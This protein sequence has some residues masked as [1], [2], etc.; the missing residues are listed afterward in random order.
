M[1]TYIY[2]SCNMYTIGWIAIS[3]NLVN[4]HLKRNIIKYQNII[5]ITI[6]AWKNNKLK[7]REQII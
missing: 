3:V 5:Y 2:F 6:M 1:I 4:F 7:R